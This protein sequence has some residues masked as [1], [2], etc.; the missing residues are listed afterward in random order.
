MLLLYFATSLGIFVSASMQ[1]PHSFSSAVKDSH[2]VASMDDE[3]RTLLV[4]HIWD[5][6]PCPSNQKII[7]LKWVYKVK[8]KPDGSVNWFKVRLVAQGYTQQEDIDYDETFS[9]IVKLVTI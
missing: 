4:N 7:G 8:Q 9:P 5:L 3:Y 6:V 1:E 2:C